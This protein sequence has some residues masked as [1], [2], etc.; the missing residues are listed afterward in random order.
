M[1]IEVQTVHKLVNVVGGFYITAMTLWSLGTTFAYVWKH[2]FETDIYAEDA[3][4]HYAHLLPP[5][6]QVFFFDNFCRA[7]RETHTKYKTF[8]PQ[9]RLDVGS[10]GRVNIISAIYGSGDF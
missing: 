1:P 2:T 4:D 6:L 5:H 9:K 3:G 10:P 8:F 7:G